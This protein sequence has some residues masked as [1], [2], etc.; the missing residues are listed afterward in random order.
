MSS[1]ICLIDKRVLTRKDHK[2]SWCGELIPKGTSVRFLSG[3]FDDSF[4]SSRMHDEC[5]A[6]CSR[7]EVED[8]YAPY[9]NQRGIAWQEE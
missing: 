8:G 1:N 3:I 6:A 4:F 5:D 2:C 7:S 9:D